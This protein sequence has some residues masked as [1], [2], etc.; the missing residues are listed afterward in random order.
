MADVSKSMEVG[1]EIMSDGVMVGI[2]TNHTA[3]F[4]LCLYSLSPFIS[5][6]AAVC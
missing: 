2:Q 5:F 6:S 3:K 1:R 4:S